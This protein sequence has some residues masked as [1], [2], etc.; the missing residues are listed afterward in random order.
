MYPF[1]YFLSFI[2]QNF[3]IESILLLIGNFLEQLLNS[4]CFSQTSLLVYIHSFSKIIGRFLPSFKEARI[5]T[6]GNEKFYQCGPRVRKL[7]RVSN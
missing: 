4:V 6:F 2:Q 7:S 5:S 1:D 3:I